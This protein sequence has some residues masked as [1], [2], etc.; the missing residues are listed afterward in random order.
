[1]S[2]A[3]GV[4][5]GRDLSVRYV[6]LAWLL[7]AA[8]SMSHALPGIDHLGMYYDEAF[9]AQQA[10]G[11]VEPSHMG[12]HPGSV[13]S[14]ELAGRPFPVRN[15]AYLGSLKSQLLIPS[16]A[17]F[18]SSPRVVRVST[19][20][21]GLFALLLG[22]LWTSRVWGARVAIV[23][24][25]LVATDPSF[26][27]FSQFEWG[28]FT[29]NLL[30]RTAGLLFVTLAWQTSHPRR[31]I[32]YAA[33]GGAAF[34]LG[35][36]SRAD[37]AL[38]LAAFAVALVAC[39]PD[40]VR[41]AL[42]ERRGPC[43]AF[44]LAWVVGA[45]PMLRSIFDLAIASSEIAERGGLTFKWEV[46]R[47]VL[48]GSQFH[49]IIALGGRFEEAGTVDA[50]AGSFVWLLPISAILLVGL[51]FLHRSEANEPS[52]NAGNAFLLVASGILVAGMLVMPGAVR[53]H[54]QLNSMPLLQIILAAALVSLWQLDDRRRMVVVSGRIVAATALAA[55]VIGNLQ[56]IRATGQAIEE[57]GGRGRFSHALND[58]AE[59]V[60]SR[61]GAGVV[62]LDWGFHEPLLFLTRHTR[63]REAIWT[64]P[65]ALE[66]GQPWVFEAGPETYYIVHDTP[67]DLFGLGP[68]L[69]RRA[70]AEDSPLV[71]IESWRDGTG[72]DAFYSVRILR[73]H[74]LVFTGEFEIY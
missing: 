22:M 5:R 46:L 24:G 38:V 21:T 20:A 11:F 43:V 50:P 70:R 65:K 72:E 44:A 10:R 36:F 55:V 71:E 26:H 41:R 45:L 61:G 62:S 53:A 33:A 1:L 3:D 34:G 29:T 28:P 58:F 17:I 39:Q 74:R 9:M 18:G 15:A 35:F 32:F 2:A 73:R 48:D 13:R 14:V 54:H 8:V 57:T 7:L 27:F 66:Q 69:L 23:G 40:T 47:H 12:S 67:Y 37:F 63:L 31:S 60:D 51:S 25:L 42:R 30:C 52:R 49:R 16:L 6:V 56:V 19:F 4:A 68:R 64:I 59:Q